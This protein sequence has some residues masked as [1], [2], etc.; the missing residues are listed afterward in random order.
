MLLV[1][2]ESL[3]HNNSHC[4]VIV[5]QSHSCLYQAVMA[6]PRACQNH[7]A[8]E[9]DVII[10][11]QRTWSP[12]YGPCL[13][14]T[15]PPSPRSVSWT[16]LGAECAC[17]RSCRFLLLCSCASVHIGGSMM[18]K[19]A[20]VRTCVCVSVREGNMTHVEL[21]CTSRLRHRPCCSLWEK[22]DHS[23]LH[24]ILTCG[25]HSFILAQGS[26]FTLWQRQSQTLHLFR[27]LR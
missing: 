9:F 2:C 5:Q 8:Y 22:S 7:W 21:R 10:P 1:G 19:R 20:A 14:I 12:V 4:L 3:V 16:H 17:V 15:A 23:A 26:S 13:C 11:R 25:D 24:H 27:C 6:R 18:N